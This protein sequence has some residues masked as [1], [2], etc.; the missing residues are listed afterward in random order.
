MGIFFFFNRVGLEIRTTVPISKQ[1]CMG[2]L[3]FKSW[4]WLTGLLLATASLLSRGSGPYSRGC[5]RLETV[6][7][8]LRASSHQSPR[9]LPLL[10][11]L[12]QP[13][14]CIFQEYFFYSLPSGWLCTADKQGLFNAE[15]DFRAQCQKWG[16]SRKDAHSGDSAITVPPGSGHN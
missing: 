14:C 13:H 9:V 15:L 2:I 3:A 12:L 16:R 5:P 8:C 7:S 6:V 10:P 11:S 1:F 4:L